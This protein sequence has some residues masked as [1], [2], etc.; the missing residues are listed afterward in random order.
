MTP[1]FV[2]CCHLTEGGLTTSRWN[3]SGQNHTSGNLALTAVVASKKEP[4]R[5]TANP[6]ISILYWSP[7]PHGKL[8]RIKPQEK[9]YLRPGASFFRNIQ[10]FFLWDQELGAAL[11]TYYAGPYLIFPHNFIVFVFLFCV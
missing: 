4:Q 1:S 3:Y 5:K 11:L 6:I 10:W 7:T 8:Q 2:G 9:D